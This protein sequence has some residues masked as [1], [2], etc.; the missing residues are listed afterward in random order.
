MLISV[1]VLWDAK[2]IYKIFIEHLWK[3]KHRFLNVFRGN[4]MLHW[5]L[6]WKKSFLFIL[7][8]FLYSFSLS[9]AQ[10]FWYLLLPLGKEAIIEPLSSGLLTQF[11]IPICFARLFFSLLCQIEV[12]WDNN[13]IAWRFP[14]K[15]FTGWIRITL[16]YWPRTKLLAWPMAIKLEVWPDFSS[17]MIKLK[18]SYLSHHLSIFCLSRT[19]T[20][21]LKWLFSIF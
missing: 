9:L 17:A 2:V 18:S 12:F 3:D 14:E 1:C 20:T 11:I 7:L 19:C 13:N 6:M 10:G 16:S 5:L 8:P 21:V 4:K 15:Q